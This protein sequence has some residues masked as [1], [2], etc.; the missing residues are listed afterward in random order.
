M[1]KSWEVM[2]IRSAVAAGRNVQTPLGH[3]ATPQGY[4]GC[5]YWWQFAEEALGLPPAC[6]PL[7]PLGCLHPWLLGV[8]A[9]FAAGGP[10]ALPICAGGCLLMTTQQEAVVVWGDCEQLDTHE[11]DIA[12]WILEQAPGVVNNFSKRK[13]NG[14]V[15]MYAHEVLFVPRGATIYVVGTAQDHDSTTFI[16]M[17]PLL[18]T[19]AMLSDEKWV[20]AINALLSGARRTPPTAC[21]ATSASSKP[22]S[23]RPRSGRR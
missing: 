16:L 7:A 19:E 8:R 10:S 17:F 9:T 13:G 15:R 12:K 5:T 20:P 11:G 2:E 14:S 21:G 18:P 6:G 3:F 1:N 4:N 23:R 22:S